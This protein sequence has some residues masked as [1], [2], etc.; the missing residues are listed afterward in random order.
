MRGYHQKFTTGIKYYLGLCRR[1]GQ[2]PYGNTYYEDRYFLFKGRKKS[3]RWVIYNGLAEGSKVPSEWHGWLHQTTNKIP[4]YDQWMKQSWRRT[5]LPNLS[6]T[7]NK[8]GISSQEEKKISY[9]A[10]LPE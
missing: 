5:H 9:K 6:G 8:E 2:D 3:R 1:A 10:W 4:S 7:L